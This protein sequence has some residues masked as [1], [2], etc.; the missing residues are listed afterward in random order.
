[1]A[2]KYI[3]QEEFT[4]LGYEIP[5]PF[6]NEFNRINH[7]TELSINVFAPLVAKANYDELT[8]EQKD[9]ITNV[10]AVL[11]D[12]TFKNGNKPHNASISASSGS[13]NSNTSAGPISIQALPYSIRDMIIGILANVELYEYNLNKNI[14]YERDKY[15]DDSFY[16]PIPNDPYITRSQADISYLKKLANG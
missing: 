3:S 1:M 15:N 10:A 14:N 9:A 16:N 11:I 5:I 6:E 7:E 2:N 4:S 8:Q 12:Y 13:F